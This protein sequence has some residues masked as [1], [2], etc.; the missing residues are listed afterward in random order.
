MGRWFPSPT[1]DVLSKVMTCMYHF[2]A[3]AALLHELFFQVPCRTL[4][5]LYVRFDGNVQEIR[6]IH[7]PGGRD[8]RG[9][10]LSL[11]SAQ[12][13]NQDID[14]PIKGR[15]NRRYSYL[16]FP[17]PT[18]P[19]LLYVYPMAMSNSCIL[20]NGIIKTL[21]A[22]WLPILCLCFNWAHMSDW[23]KFQNNLENLKF[24]KV[25]L[26][27]IVSPLNFEGGKLSKIALGTFIKRRMFNVYP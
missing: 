8:G 23:R 9:R 20:G 19:N 26:R 7:W 24:E 25:K 3:I 22:A 17:S 2:H 12:K 6:V 10:G 15:A 13:K 27:K 18:Y 11:I 16:S 21:L 1:D 5:L 4:I 14:T